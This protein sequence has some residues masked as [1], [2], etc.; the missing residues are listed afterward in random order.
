MGK[1]EGV[2]KNTIIKDK[3]G[4]RVKQAIIFDPMIAKWNK[5][6]VFFYFIDKLLGSEIGFNQM[7]FDA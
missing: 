1:S 5:L 7:A 3:G 2:R 6:K 4:K